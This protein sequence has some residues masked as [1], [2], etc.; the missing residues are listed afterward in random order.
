MMYVDD[1][2]YELRSGIGDILFA[3]NNLRGPTW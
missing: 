1:M 3:P 2:V